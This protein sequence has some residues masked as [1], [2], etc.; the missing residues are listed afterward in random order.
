MMASLFEATAR[1]AL[2]GGRD[3][4]PMLASPPLGAYYSFRRR[5]MFIS[6]SRFTDDYR[7]R[8]VPRK[9]RRESS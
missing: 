9:H 2:A 8:R 4:T 1:R 6:F 7:L 3:F 5:Q